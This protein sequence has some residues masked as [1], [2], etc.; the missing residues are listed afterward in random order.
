MRYI[1]KGKVDAFPK[2]FIE[3]KAD[4]GS[5]DN[6]LTIN[7]RGDKFSRANVPTAMGFAN[8]GVDF[9]GLATELARV[10]TTAVG[11]SFVA[12]VDVAVGGN[13]LVRV[14]ITVNDGQAV[15]VRGEIEKAIGT[16]VETT[17]GTR[18]WVFFNRG[19]GRQNGSFVKQ[20]ATGNIAITVTP[21][22]PLV[23]TGGNPV[24]ITLPAPLR[25][26]AND[27]T[28]GATDPLRM[29]RIAGVGAIDNT[30]QA[31]GVRADNIPAGLVPSYEYISD[32]AMRVTLER[33]VGTPHLTTIISTM[34]IMS[35]LTS[36]MTLWLRAFAPMPLR[37]YR[38]ISAKRSS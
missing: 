3:S 15:D 19:G 37:I 26:I 11:T 4:D 30:V 10:A 17:A 7:I 27:A 23:D 8:N 18:E 6:D 34:S 36:A 28:I 13:R 22:T 31:G 29:V 35:V 14:P 38:S 5:I 9:A 1:E 24:P 20:Q 33:P 32:T 2:Q 12:N 25:N 21:T 16:G